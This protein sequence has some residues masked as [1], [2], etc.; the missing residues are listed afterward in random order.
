MLTAAGADG[1]TLSEFEL[2]GTLRGVEPGTHPSD[3]RAAATKPSPTPSE[4]ID[5]TSG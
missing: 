1:V 5:R 2:L 4:S 3:K